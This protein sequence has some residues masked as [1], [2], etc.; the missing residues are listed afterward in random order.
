MMAAGMDGFDLT[1]LDRRVHNIWG[2][3]VDS[4]GEYNE[5]IFLSTSHKYN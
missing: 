5:T 4:I 2:L 3:T 1:I